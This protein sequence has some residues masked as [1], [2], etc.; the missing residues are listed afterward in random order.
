MLGVP[1]PPASGTYEVRAG[2]VPLALAGPDDH[3]PVRFVTDARASEYLARKLDLLEHHADAVRLRVPARS[4]ADDDALATILRDALGWLAAEHPERCVVDGDAIA[5][6]PFGVLLRGD[7][8]ERVAP[9]APGLGPLARNAQTWLARQRGI[10]L[11]ADALALSV[12]EDFAVVRAPDDDDDPAGDVLELMHICFP[13]HWAPAEKL[14][15]NFAAVHAPVANNG[16]IIGAHRQLVRAMVRKGPLL[17]YAWS[18]AR[19]P[20]LDLNPRLHHLA[21]PPAAAYTDPDAAARATWYRVE[22]QTTN[23]FP[24]LGR[25]L[26]TIRTWVVP[27]TEVGE[28]PARARQLASAIRSMRDDEADYKGIGK[29][30]APLVAWLEGRGPAGQ[31]A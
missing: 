22:R 24:A 25:S 3:G 30:R 28:D 1:F 15:G 18:I 23:P 16:V 17:R 7:T 5:L 10:D 29:L 13:S 4:R 6:P 19:D 11:L 21:E 27:M 31:G 14:G 2:L 9:P 12:M 8:V 20:R 26:F